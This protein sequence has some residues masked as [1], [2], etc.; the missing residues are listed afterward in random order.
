MDESEI[1]LGQ[2]S[3][4]QQEALNQYTQVTNQEVNEAIPLLRRSEWNVQVFN[5]IQYAL[6]EIL[7][8]AHRS[9]SPSSLTAKQLTQ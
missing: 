9:Q 5:F 7:T 6:L 2:L 3:S 1:N 8:P 4:T